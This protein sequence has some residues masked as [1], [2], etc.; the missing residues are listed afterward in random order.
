MS[1]L[2]KVK[3]AVKSRPNQSMM[4]ED[5]FSGTRMLLVRIPMSYEAMLRY[6]GRWS[7]DHDVHSE[8]LAMGCYLYNHLVGDRARVKDR[9]TYYTVS[10]FRTSSQ[11]VQSWNTGGLRLEDIS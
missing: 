3:A 6:R 1:S 7:G 5:D 11:V 8:Q 4:S 2:I 9:L 10:H